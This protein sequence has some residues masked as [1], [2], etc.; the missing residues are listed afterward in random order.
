MRFN[1]AVLDSLL[2]STALSKR[3]V[4]AVT[5]S[6]QSIVLNLATLSVK[7]QKLLEEEVY[8]N[9]LATAATFSRGGL[10]VPSMG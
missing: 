3:V 8:I 6:G 5:F 4:S 1:K 10:D 2:N 7:M 9:T